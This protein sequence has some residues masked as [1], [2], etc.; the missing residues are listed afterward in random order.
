[1]LKS[2]GDWGYSERAAGAG[3]PLAQATWPDTGVPETDLPFLGPWK[4]SA[5]RNGSGWHSCPPA[6]CRAGTSLSWC[7]PRCLP[8]LL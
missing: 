6:L 4:G 8:K 7:F 5:L 3:K 2:R 1:M